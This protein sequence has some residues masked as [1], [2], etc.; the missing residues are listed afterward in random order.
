MN[1][2][3]FFLICIALF[4]CERDQCPGDRVD[5]AI[6]II[7]ENKKGENL[8]NPNTIGNLLNSDIKVFEVINGIEKEFYNSKLDCPRNYCLIDDLSSGKLFRLF[9]SNNFE[10]KKANI[11]IRWNSNDS[12]NVIAKIV[13]K[14][15]K[16]NTDTYCDS[17]WVNGIIKFPN[18]DFSPLRKFLIIK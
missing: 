1:L 12:D 10:T 11:I 4:S 3:L 16:C 17:V 15:D 5:I 7:I 2:K 9:P 6:D 18:M 8:F 13:S 14:S